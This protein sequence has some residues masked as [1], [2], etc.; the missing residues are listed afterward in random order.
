MVGVAG[1]IVLQSQFDH[2]LLFIDLLKVFFKFKTMLLQL[3]DTHKN[4]TKGL[5]QK[6]ENK[7]I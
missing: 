1:L 4:S 5:S 3:N 2:F 7:L 6:L